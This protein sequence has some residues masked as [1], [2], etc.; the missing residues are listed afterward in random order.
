MYCPGRESPLPGWGGGVKE[1]EVINS[2]GLGMLIRACEV[3]KTLGPLS[4][5]FTETFEGHIP[6]PLMYTPQEFSKDCFILVFGQN[7]W[8]H[9]P[10]LKIA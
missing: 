8:C 2:L 3:L 10:R 6:L 4:K 5:H 1:N 9:N 7:W